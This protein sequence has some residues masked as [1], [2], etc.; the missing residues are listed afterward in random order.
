[1]T[2]ASDTAAASTGRQPPKWLM[3]S[4]E[5]QDRPAANPRKPKAAAQG[6]R[7]VPDWVR[8]RIDVDALGYSR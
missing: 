4:W 2:S 7:R 1:M 6:P 8:R 3:Q 5:R